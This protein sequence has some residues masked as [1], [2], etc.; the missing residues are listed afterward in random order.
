MA[1]ASVAFL[2]TH[3][4]AFQYG[5][6]QGIYAV[7][8]Q[9]M[10]EGVPPY[11]GTWD[12]K[13]PGIFFV[14]ALAQAL[15][16]PHMYA[17]RI[18]EAAGLASLVAAFVLLSRRHVG[19]ARA[20]IIGGTF[21][22]LIHVQLEFWQTGQPS[23][24]A[25]IALAWALVCATYEPE[26][27]DTP[28][29]R[30]KQIAAWFGAGMLYAVAAVLKPPLGGGIVASLAVAI[31]RQ[32]R[33]SVSQTRWYSL[34][35]PTLAF[36]GGAL[37]PLVSVAAYFVATDAWRDCLETL[38]VFTPQYTALSF[39]PERFGS[40]LLRAV[41]E[42]AFAFSALNPVG[43]ALVTGLPAL[44]GRE[45]EGILHVLSVVGF[46]LVGV[47]LQAKFFP[48]HYGAALP[49]TALLAGWGLWK[50]WLLLG[51][52][53]HGAVLVALLVCLLVGSRAAT[54]ELDDSFWTRCQMRHRLWL[55]PSIGPEIND[56]LYSMAD[57]DA[58]A[59]RLVS[60]WLSVHT[61][62]GSP[63]FVWGF[64]P[65]VYALAQR[66]PGSRY[67]YNAPQRVKWADQ[68]ARQV[69]ID[70][71]QQSRPKAIVVEHGDHLPWVTGNKLDSAATLQE[72]AALQALIR[73][74]YEPAGKIR[75]FDLYLRKGVKPAG[76]Q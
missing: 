37:V 73:D 61:P 5:R 43:L 47:A 24:F 66:P 65:V 48:Y 60:Q 38:F 54:I 76:Q 57:V 31:H 7:V 10:L 27:P 9:R 44:H 71:L 34:G 18:L 59:N 42:W 29:C 4:I 72:F 25:A 17:V 64:E 1:L 8:A 69:L 67:I 23:S 28:Y 22:V 21:A 19:S 11:R 58:G 40:L 62:P 63:V 30:R 50:L 49:L 20:G 14:Y 35:I 3:L 32:Q 68:H 55:D 52:R 51:V 56:R 39:H 70:D 41:D 2:L 15:F 26:A 45:R 74:A 36:A 13:P 53:P 46:I 33:S 6:D 16:G 12:F 75:R